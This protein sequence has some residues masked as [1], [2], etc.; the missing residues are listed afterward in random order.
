MTRTILSGSLSPPAA[1][2]LSLRVGAG[3]LP[4]D[5][6]AA[7][8]SQ[9]PNSAAPEEDRVPLLVSPQKD[10]GCLC[11]VLTLGSMTVGKRME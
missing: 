11:S 8:G 2:A 6:Q 5:A 3:R 10:T 7:L 4:P 1:S 9:C